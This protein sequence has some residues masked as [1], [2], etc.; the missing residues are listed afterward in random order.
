[1]VVVRT[2]KLLPALVDL[3]EVLFV[4]RKWHGV[5]NLKTKLLEPVGQSNR[6]FHDKIALTKSPKLSA[7]LSAG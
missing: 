2:K 1:M 6:P 7:L 3:P 5:N 4:E